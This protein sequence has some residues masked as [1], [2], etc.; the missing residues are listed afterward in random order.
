MRSRQK[1]K[2]FKKK[3]YHNHVAMFRLYRENGSTATQVND[4]IVIIIDRKYGVK[5]CKLKTQVI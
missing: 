5:S 2:N 4:S 1:I 3:M